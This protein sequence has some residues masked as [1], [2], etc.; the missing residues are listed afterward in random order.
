MNIFVIDINPIEAAVYLPDALV[1]KMPVETAQ[2]VATSLIYW[3]QGS[4][5]KSKVEPYFPPTPVYTRLKKQA[6]AI[7]EAPS[8]LN[9]RVEYLKAHKNHPCAVW[10]R[11]CIGNLAWLIEHGLALCREYTERYG[12][13]H[14]SEWPLIIARYKLLDFKQVSTLKELYTPIS[15]RCTYPS[16]SV[17]DDLVLKLNNRLIDQG[18]ES[19]IDY[20]DSTNYWIPLTYIYREY[21]ARKWYVQNGQGYKNMKSLSRKR[22]L[23]AA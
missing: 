22:F 3:Q 11:E 23:E 8:L 6:K 18:L 21:I 1:I 9:I 12:K 17:D 16:A 13:I 14:G 15:S 4:I 19:N 7:V 2:L 20:L 5:P 10:G